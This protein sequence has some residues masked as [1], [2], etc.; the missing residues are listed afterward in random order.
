MFLMTF[1][2]SWQLRQYAVQLDGLRVVTLGDKTVT[3]AIHVFKRNPNWVINL[4]T[5]EPEIIELKCCLSG[6][7]TTGNQTAFG[8]GTCNKQNC[9]MQH[10]LDD[11]N[12]F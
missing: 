4:R 11:M 9:D 5:W 6:I 2:A 10:H 12:V 1:E 7:I 8:C 3:Q